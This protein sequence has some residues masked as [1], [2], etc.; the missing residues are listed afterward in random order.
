MGGGRGREGLGGRVVVMGGDLLKLV[1]CLTRTH[2]L[3]LRPHTQG[4]TISLLA[5]LEVTYLL[6]HSLTYSLTYLLGYLLT[7][8]LTCLAGLGVPGVPLMMFVAYWPS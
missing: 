4:K 2:G 5:G 1:S 8:L 6:T 7:Y 3:I